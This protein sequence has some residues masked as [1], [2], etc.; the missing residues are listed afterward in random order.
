MSAA[1]PL[2]HDPTGWPYFTELSDVGPLARPQDVAAEHSP[3]E[4]PIGAAPAAPVQSVGIT[5]CIR[6]RIRSQEDWPLVTKAPLTEARE[7]ARSR[8]R[9]PTVMHAKRKRSRTPTPH[10]SPQR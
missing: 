10:S 2:S 1:Q 3:C 4:Q 7:G 9:H 6:T 8:Q 5:E